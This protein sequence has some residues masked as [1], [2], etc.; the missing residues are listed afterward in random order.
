MKNIS[1][2]LLSI[3]LILFHSCKKDDNKPKP[4]E[5]LITLHFTDRF[6]HEQLPVIV[7]LSDESGKT[8]LDTTCVSNETYELFAASGQS[9]P[10][11]M[12]VTVVSSEPYWHSLRVHINTY[13][14]VEK[15]AE[16]TLKGS[17]MDT[18][19]TAYVSL[20]NVPDINGPILYA[21]PGYYT[22]TFNKTNRALLI[23]DSPADFYVKIRTDTGQYFKYVPDC[24]VFGDYTADMSV[25]M[26]TVSKKVLFPMPVENFEAKLF[27]YA[28]A[29]LDSPGPL[30]L[31][32]AMSEGFVADSLQ[33]NFP[34]DLF[35]Y[36]QTQI[37]LQETYLSDVSYFQ[38]SEGNIPSVFIRPDAEI[39]TMQQEQ[40]KLKI[41]SKGTFDLVTAD[42]Q[43]VDYALMH[44]EW[45]VF[46][47]DTSKTVLLPEITK[48]FQKMYPTIS[49]D[50]LRFQFTELTDFQQI[51]SYD[52]LMGK[53]FDSGKPTRM[54]RLA[55][56]SIRKS[57]L[58]SSRKE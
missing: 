31:D 57:L 53:M 18:V 41:E 35:N 10:D 44:Y 50:S 54:D 15:G 12:M 56:N 36:F 39:L 37:M 24:L 2:V 21:S 9:V 38:I 4:A 52:A 26:P 29:D 11:R 7:F 3:L 22:L 20:E 33:L 46:A 25:N 16:W 45:K 1:F 5:P 17:R 27:A 14:R 28:D 6:V 42:W 13:T 30:I 8:I 48:A 43:F 34:P 23:Y 47:S 55:A 49:H 19:A 58:P 51:E 32:Y 40:N